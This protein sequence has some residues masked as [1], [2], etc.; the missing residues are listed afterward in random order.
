MEGR[1]WMR[2]SYSMGPATTSWTPSASRTLTGGSV[3]FMA[4]PM[5]RVRQGQPLAAAAVLP[6]P[7]PGNHLRADWWRAWGSHSGHEQQQPGPPCGHLGPLGWGVPWTPVGTLRQYCCSCSICG[8]DLRH[9][10][11]G[12]AQLQYCGP[13]A[14]KSDHRLGEK[15][16]HLPKHEVP[17]LYLCDLLKL[18]TWKPQ[19]QPRSLSALVRVNVCVGMRLSFFK[20]L[21]G[22]NSKLSGKLQE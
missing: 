9:G 3:A 2:D 19:A 17:G 21:I 11:D 10:Q 1:L 5:A 16:R 8:L 4:L 12:S 7:G 22:N 14:L 20:A 18:Q 6:P 15:R 13:E